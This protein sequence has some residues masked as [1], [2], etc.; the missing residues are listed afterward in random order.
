MRRLILSLTICAAML[1]AV[2]ASAQYYQI[3]NQIPGL[4][5]P[6]L[7]G[8]L[9]YKGFVEFSGLAG[10]GTNRANFIELSTTQGFRYSDWFFMGAGVGI[11][12]AMAQNP[13]RLSSLPD[14]DR[15]DYWG[16][17][18]SKTMAMV[19]VFSDFRF[20]IG[21]GAGT[22]MFID[23]RLGAAWLL[24]SNYLRLE[25]GCLTN[26]TQ[27]YFRPTVGVRIPVSAQNARQAI[28][29]GLTYQLLTS[30]DNWYWNDRSLTLHSLGA[31][32]SFEW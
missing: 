16:H 1:G 18:Y 28:N 20:N 13:D 4:I 15:P 21:T 14:V 32:V 31:S 11:D 27:F 24:G 30:N 17:G 29:I 2:T 3:A 7:S 23:L 5:S 6:A 10:L 26:G 22:A 8:S 12:V 9:N 25:N 19:P